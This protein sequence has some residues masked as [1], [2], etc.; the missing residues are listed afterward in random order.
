M[1]LLVTRPAADAT[2]LAQ[3]LEAAGHAVIID[4]LIDI[5]PIAGA[6][7]DLD[8]VTGVLFTSAN[9]V[10][11]FAAASDR[12]DLTVFAVGGITALTATDLGF[13]AVESADGDVAALVDLVLARRKPED[14]ILLHAGGAVRAGNLQGVLAE[15]GFEVR[16]AILYEGVEASGLSTAT[17]ATIRDGSLD[18]ILLFSPRTAKLFAKLAEAAGLGPATAKLQ[19]WCLSQAVADGLG[20]LPLTRR[21]VADE[22]NQAALLADIAAGAKPTPAT[23]PSGSAPASSGRWL[24]AAAVIVVLLGAGVSA[25]WWWPL[26]NPPHAST[27]PTP[28]V[29]ETPAPLPSPTAIVPQAAPPPTEPVEDPRIDRIRDTLA[30]LEARLSTLEARPDT[31][32]EQI[33]TLKVQLSAMATRIAALE[34]RQASERGLTLAAGQI[35]VA[36]AGSGPWAA[37]LAILQTAAAGDATLDEPIAA[38]AVRAKTGVPTR[39]RLAEDLATLPAKLG[40][41]PPP[42]PE[43]TFW[44]RLSD[45]ASRIV[46]IRRVDDGSGTRLPPGPDRVLAA[47]NAALA[48]GDLAGAV[49]IIEGLNPPPGTAL[50]DWLDA[51]KS[52]LAAEQALDRLDAALAARLGETERKA[53]SPP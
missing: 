27:Q 31:A 8:G 46:T 19:A 52:R 25:H 30:R 42:G 41:Q 48:G 22:P 40:E 7:P 49:Q 32:S 6:A 11:A 38:L 2:A 33:E 36:L 47:A 4:P 3:T 51:A 45:R 53:G 21:H 29:T 13:T 44:E 50:A 12:R 20:D 10:R 34:G 1:K 18:G 28:V 9:G 39:V 16:L 15:K 43:A 5:R 14:G 23:P 37:P 35:R 17:L 24:F 26:L